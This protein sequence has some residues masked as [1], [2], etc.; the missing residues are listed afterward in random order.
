[1]LGSQIIITINAALKVTIIKDHTIIIIV[2]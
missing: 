2:D 1:M